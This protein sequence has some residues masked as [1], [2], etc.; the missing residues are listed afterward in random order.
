MNSASLSSSQRLQRVADVL[1][2]GSELS[3]RQ[4]IQRAK[5]CAVNSIVA[6]LRDNGMDIACTRRRV[7]GEWRWFYRKAA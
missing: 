7:R 1:K 4:I 6:E 3:T 5:V 2:D